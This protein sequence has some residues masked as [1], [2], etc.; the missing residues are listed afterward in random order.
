MSNVSDQ[1]TTI[2]T[3]KNVVKEFVE[4]RDWRQFHTPKN[5]AMS[6]CIEGAELMEHFQWLTP[7]ESRELS[8][9][10]KV[11][12]GEEMADVLCYLLGMANEM[13]IDLADALDKKM[14]KNRIKYPCEE[15]R[16]RFGKDDPRPV[17]E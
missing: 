12:V 1:L 10:K 9:E 4:E 17:D 6:L 5:L 8:D 14:V 15:F 16:G 2:E 13:S 7:Q 3:L 11:E